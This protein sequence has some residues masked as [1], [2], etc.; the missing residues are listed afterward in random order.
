MES[1][2]LLTNSSSVT[3]AGLREMWMVLQGDTLTLQYGLR[4]LCHV[5]AKLVLPQDLDACVKGFTFARATLGRDGENGPGMERV[6]R[7]V[8]CAAV[9][10]YW[11]YPTRTAW[12][13]MLFE[14]KG[15]Q[16]GRRFCG[17]SI[18]RT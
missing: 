16:E 11:T 13:W 8:G 18:L 10:G 7:G 9:C 6:D 5:C 17:W 14:E 12:G 3:F 4:R 2:N 1:T 15:G